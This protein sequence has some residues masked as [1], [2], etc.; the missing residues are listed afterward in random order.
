M[1]REMTFCDVLGIHERPD[2]RGRLD[3][4]ADAS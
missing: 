1:L 4:L 2:E 3:P